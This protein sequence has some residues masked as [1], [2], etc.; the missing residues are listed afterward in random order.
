M[1]YS[2][3]SKNFFVVFRFIKSDDSGYIPALI[4]EN[5]DILIRRVAISL[6]F[7]TFFNWSHKGDKFTW[8]NRVKISIFDSFVLFIMFY[9]E[10]FETIPSK[11]N[12][13]F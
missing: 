1:L 10:I 6:I 8:N 4:F 12:T 13:I 11:L 5:S 3:I 2:C 7:T 9:I